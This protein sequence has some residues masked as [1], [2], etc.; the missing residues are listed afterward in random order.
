MDDGGGVAQPDQDQVGDEPADA[1]VAVQKRVDALEG[2][3]VARDCFC[4]RAG[5]TGQQFDPV[6]PILHQGGDLRMLRRRHS[7]RKGPDVML[8]PV[9]GALAVEGVRR[10]GDLPD[11]CHGQPVD[12]ADLCERQ[13]FAAGPALGAK[14]LAVNPL[15]RL[16]V[17][18]NLQVVLEL[19][20][21]DCPAL[22]EENLD[23]LP[24]QGVAF[25][26]GGV[27]GLVVPDLSP[28]PLGFFGAGE[29]T[30]AGAELLDREGELLVDG[31][32]GWPTSGRQVS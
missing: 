12:L 14:S 18:L 10:R 6:N 16:R 8:A 7:L 15:G 28:D 24:D 5:I 27:V 22:I 25:Q 3:V 23:L 9:A 13:E 30:Q 2:G 31:L 11:R 1:A 19:L 32:S 17:A 20:V 4:N 26:G 29:S 21:P